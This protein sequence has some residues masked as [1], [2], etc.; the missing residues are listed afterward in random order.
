VVVG[1]SESVCVSVFEFV[2]EGG[3]AWAISGWRVRNKIKLS[4]RV[5]R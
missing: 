3:A 2:F 5:N 1:V 4:K